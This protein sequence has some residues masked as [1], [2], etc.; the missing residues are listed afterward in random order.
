MQ[1]YDDLQGGELAASI[2]PMQRMDLIQKGYNPMSADD[3]KRYYNNQRPI[4][5]LQE[6]AGVKKY[7]SLGGGSEVDKRDAGLLQEFENE[8]GASLTTGRI[9]QSGNPREDVRGM[10]NNYGSSSGYDLDSKISRISEKVQQSKQRQLPPTSQDRRLIQTPKQ[11][12]PLITESAKAKKIGYTIGLRYINAFITNVKAP[13][14]ANRAILMKE[15]NNLVL[16][17]D[18]I[19]PQ[20]LKEYRQGIAIAESELYNRIKTKGE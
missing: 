9:N 3:V 7:T 6:V 19:A 14:S 13:S 15:M 16:L 20:L 4:E 2:T 18:K 17:E 5:G 1:Q 12:L 8:T 11:T 10:M